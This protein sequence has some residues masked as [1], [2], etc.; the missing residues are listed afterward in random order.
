MLAWSCVR[1][2][3]ARIVS[4]GYRRPITWARCISAYLVDNSMFCR[5][6]F[7]R[8]RGRASTS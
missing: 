1:I 4:K 3:A 7:A 6:L 5:A 8:N 2:I